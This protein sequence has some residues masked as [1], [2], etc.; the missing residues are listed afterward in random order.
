MIS[1]FVLVYARGYGQRNQ[2]L[3]HWMENQIDAAHG[4]GGH[5]HGLVSLIKRSYPRILMWLRDA[6]PLLDRLLEP[7]AVYDNLLN[8]SAPVAA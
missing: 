3:C 7:Y 1:N 5:H 8:A 4:F 6:Y 2:N